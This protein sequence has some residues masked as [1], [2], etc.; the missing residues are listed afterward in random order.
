[1]EFV[2]GVL[3][4][5]C[6]APSIAYGHR[7]CFRKIRSV[8]SGK[9]LTASGEILNVDRRGCASHLQERHGTFQG[10]T[11]LTTMAACP[12]TAQ[13]TDAWMDIASATSGTGSSITE[14]RP[15]IESPGLRLAKAL[16]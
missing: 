1:L 9:D 16:L 7:N 8:Q 4:A 6:Y 5:R 15:L 13:A 10:T 12:S 14:P 2:I 3:V 11:T